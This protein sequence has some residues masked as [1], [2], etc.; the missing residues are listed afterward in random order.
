MF[1][2]HPTDLLHTLLSGEIS[3]GDLAIDATAG[4]G[5]DTIFLARAVG[6]DGKVIAMDIQEIA[7]EATRLRLEN[8]DFL[9][10]ATIHH[11]SHTRIA[12][13]AEPLT[14]KAI[15]FNLGYLPGADRSITTR[16]DETL[17]A[18]AASMEILVH[19]GILAV[20]CYPGHPEGAEESEAVENY[21]MNSSGYRI[22]RYSLLT[23]RSATPFLLLVRRGL[24]KI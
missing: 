14:A 12:E 19:G 18:I 7:V 3:H 9:D 8:D 20:V 10:R 16:K 5:H 6:A 23:N 15:L 13:L 11:L 4:N 17:Q 2:P 1:P 21:L 24:R 22:A